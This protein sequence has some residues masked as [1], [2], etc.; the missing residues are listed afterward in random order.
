MSAA[1]MRPRTPPGTNGRGTPQALLGRC[2][3]RFIPA[4]ISYF[5]K[6]DSEANDREHQEKHEVER[7]FEKVKRDSILGN[8]QFVRDNSHV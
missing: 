8:E 6:T 5:D 1:G 4:T 7:G 2:A 3:T